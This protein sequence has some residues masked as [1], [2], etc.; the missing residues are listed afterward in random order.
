MTERREGG[1]EQPSTTYTKTS[2]TAQKGAG[3]YLTATTEKKGTEGD[4]LGYNP[5]PEDLRLW[6]VYG[7]WVHA[8]PGTLLNG[9]IS[10]DAAW[11]GVLV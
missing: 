11:E 10:N 3:K 1:K 7:D 6:K 8:K 9:G 5:T 2:G 4:E